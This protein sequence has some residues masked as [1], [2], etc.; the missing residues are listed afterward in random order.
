MSDVRGLPE[1]SPVVIWM[2]A[3]ESFYLGCSDAKKQGAR[4]T[5]ASSPVVVTF[6]AL[7]F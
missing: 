1:C 6:D 7:S 4:S 5:N 3:K 2:A